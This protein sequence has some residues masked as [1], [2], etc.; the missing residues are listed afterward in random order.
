MFQE[1][2]S[3]GKELHKQKDPILDS[4]IPQLRNKKIHPDLKELREK[5]KK[6]K[7][8]NLILSLIVIII[9]YYVINNKIWNL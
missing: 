4:H 6:N 8:K 1:E 7:A 5:R 2:L 9:Y 3:F